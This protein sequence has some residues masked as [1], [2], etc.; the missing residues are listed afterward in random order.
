VSEIGSYDLS[1]I[2]GHETTFYFTLRYVAGFFDFR[3][4]PDICHNLS[5]FA[6]NKHQKLL[7]KNRKSEKT[8]L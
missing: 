6:N 5:V 8:A 3:F 4:L 2:L 7:V 1:G